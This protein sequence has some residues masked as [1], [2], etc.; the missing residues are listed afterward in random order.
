MKQRFQKIQ[1]MIKNTLKTAVLF[2]VGLLSTTAFSQDMV[3]PDGGDRVTVKY[4]L[5]YS[6][7]M[8]DDVS[9]I[10]HKWYSNGQSISIMVN[11]DLGKN[12][13][14]SIGG[15]MSTYYLHNNLNFVQLGPD[16]AAGNDD[17]TISSDSAYNAN[18]QNLIYYEIPVELT[19]KTN[20]N[21]KSKGLFLTIGAKAGYRLG[22]LWGSNVSESSYHRVDDYTIRRYRNVGDSRFRVQGYARLGYGNVALFAGMDLLPLMNLE[23]NTGSAD[24]GMA[25]FGLTFNFM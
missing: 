18:E 17:F 4:D 21:S 10:T 24:I 13:R 16:D 23:T 6:I 20:S 25:S 22:S 15:G 5:T 8:S 1:K 7:A 9:D 2:A 12:V 3:L 11:S 14:F 19:F